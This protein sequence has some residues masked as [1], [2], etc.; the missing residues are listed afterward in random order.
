M[1]WK[2]NLVFLSLLALILAVIKNKIMNRAEVWKKY[3]EFLYNQEGEYGGS[4][5]DKGGAWGGWC[6]KLY[7]GQ[8]IHTRRGITWGSFV[9][10]GPKLGYSPT[11]ELF[12]EMPTWLW[13]KILN[14]VFKDKYKGID[15]LMNSVPLLAIDIID[16]GFMGGG[17][18]PSR[19]INTIF[20]E[21][22]TQNDVALTLYK[23]SESRKYTSEQL[24]KMITNERWRR[25]K[26]QSNF[27]KFGK[28]WANRLNKI[29][30][31]FSD[32]KHRVF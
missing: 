22:T 9:N 6:P 5:I 19:H 7:K 4:K 29:T 1:N 15:K 3:L 18:A 32:Y 12:L 10:N 8:Q 16:M 20:N 2:K 31:N 13:N 25:L 21:D 28:G 30:A 17:S 24:H 27:W 26:A 11:P 23:I 14:Q